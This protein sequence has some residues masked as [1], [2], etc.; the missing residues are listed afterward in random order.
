MFGAGGLQASRGCSAWRSADLRGGG[1]T[2]TRMLRSKSPVTTLTCPYCK[3]HFEWFSAIVHC[4]KCRTAYHDICWYQQTT[5]ATYGC[6]GFE[7]IEERK[8]RRHELLVTAG[9]TIAGVAAVIFIPLCIAFGL[10]IL[11]V[12]AV[13]LVYK[14]VAKMIG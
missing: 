7:T 14:Y 4:R 12:T 11:P 1:H 8:D 10:Y 3:S 6:N 2:R 5:C 13:I 9:L